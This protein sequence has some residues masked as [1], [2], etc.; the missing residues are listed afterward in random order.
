[1]IGLVKK[2]LGI[3]AQ[4]EGPSDEGAREHRALVATTA[5]LLEI[6]HIDGSFTDE[7]KER[8]VSI[9]TRDYGL[10]FSE[11]EAIMES[12]REQMNRSVDLWQFT[13]VINRHFSVEEKVKVIEMVWRVIY[14]DG[15]LDKYEDY[16][17]RT[18]SDLLHLDHCHFIETK[19]KT[20]KAAEARQPQGRPS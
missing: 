3:S 14:A 16:L 6:A 2:M 20:R 19:L 9:L 7:E 15:R 11:A 17:V 5:L 8:I 1:M 18:L 12:A 13:N 10:R 4:G